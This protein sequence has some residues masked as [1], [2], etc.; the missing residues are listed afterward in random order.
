MNYWLMKTEP[1]AFSIDDFLTRKNQTEGWNGVRN[2]E[3]RNLMRD[4]M[5]VGD[6]VIIYHSNAHPSGAAGVAKVASSAY[7]DPDQFDKKSKY[8][9]PKATPETP[10]WYQ[11]DVQLVK[12]FP[13]LIPLDEI[14]REPRLDE[15]AMLRRNRLSITPLTASEFRVF[16]E[17]GKGTTGAAILQE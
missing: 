1:N 13:R 5:R 12:K 10:R 2:F 15:L 7:P 3:A 6:L 14:R 17:L 4:R 8:F 9:D 16:G 11:V